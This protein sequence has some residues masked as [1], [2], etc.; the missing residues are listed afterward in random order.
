METM[1]I[2]SMARSSVIEFLLMPLLE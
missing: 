2:E 1:T